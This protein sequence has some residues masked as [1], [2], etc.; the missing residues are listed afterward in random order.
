MEKC[1]ALSVNYTVAE[2]TAM[3]HQ[4]SGLFYFIT[5]SHTKVRAARELAFHARNEGS[6]T[7]VHSRQLP[8]L[9][10]HYDTYLRNSY[11]ILHMMF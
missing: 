4:N 10:R 5:L 3:T 8:D 2:P 9:T 1:G 11:W 7:I 6:G